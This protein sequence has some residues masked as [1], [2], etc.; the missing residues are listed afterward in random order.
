MESD[1]LIGLRYQH[2]ILSYSY[3]QEPAAGVTET[4]HSSGYEGLESAHH[5]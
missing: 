2:L 5:L 4:E 3:A 1:Q